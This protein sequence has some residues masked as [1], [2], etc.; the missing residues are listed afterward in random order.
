VGQVKNLKN[1]VERLRLHWTKEEDDLIRDL[2]HIKS[3][4]EIVTLLD[5]KKSHN[6]RQ[7]AKV[8]GL[9]TVQARGWTEEEDKVLGNLF[10]SV[11]AAEIGKKINRSANSVRWRAERLGIKKNSYWT[12]K[13]DGRLLSLYYSHS[14]KEITHI[15]G[16][17]WEAVRLR[18]ERL[19]KKRGLILKN[20]WN[21]VDHS[22]FS[23]LNL[24]NCYWAGFIAADGS[25]HNNQLRIELQSKDMLHLEL[26][27]HC[28]SFTGEIHTSERLTEH[29]YLSKTSNILVSSSS[30]VKDLRNNF[31]IIPRKTHALLPPGIKKERLLKSYIIGLIDGDGGIYNYAYPIIQITGNKN[32]VSFVKEKLD[33]WFPKSFRKRFPK[34][35][36]IKNKTYSYSVGGERA[37]DIIQGLKQIETPKL[38]RKWNKI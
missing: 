26:F 14:I 4:H 6:V 2:Y 27:K 34:I 20:P 13:D 15:L 37:R 35:R 24:E 38:E 5:N 17:S 30:W 3:S 23:K 31:G 33:L 25:V 21:N 36:L 12:E 9:T 29:G 19:I 8:L 11:N 22:Y 32:I 28:C 1:V 7:R 16:R 10:P 18:A